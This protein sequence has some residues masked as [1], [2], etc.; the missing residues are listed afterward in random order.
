MSY[1]YWE[2]FTWKLIIALGKRLERAVVKWKTEWTNITYN[3]LNVNCSTHSTLFF[4]SSPTLQPVSI[5]NMSVYSIFSCKYLVHC[6]FYILTNINKNI[7][8][9]TFTVNCRHDGCKCWLYFC[10]YILPMDWR[11]LKCLLYR[12][13]MIP[14]VLYRK[15][16]RH[17]IS[18]P[19]LCSHA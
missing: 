9:C 10:I 1:T 6:C 3:S 17:Q 8:D 16:S 19:K 4:F 14:Q 5:L 13:Y 7:K 2:I 15:I 11:E 18:T 12:K